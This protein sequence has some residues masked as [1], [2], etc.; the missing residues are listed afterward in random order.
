MPYPRGVEDMKHRNAIR[1]CRRRCHIE[2]LEERRLLANVPVGYTESVLAAELTS[3]TTLDIEE[4]GRIWVAFQDGR[5]E[6]IEPGES[7]TSFAYQLDADG[8][9]EHGLQGIEL[10]PDFENNHYIYV[11]YTA[12]SPQPHNRL[13]RLTVDPTTENTILPGSEVPL[14]E[15]PNLS[16]Y[17]N[18][19]W[20]IGGAIHFDLDGYLY[21]QIGESQQA[22]QSQELDSPLG[23]VFRINA[24]GSIPT[25]NPYYNDADGITW[26]DYIWA[27]GLRNP[28]AGDLDPVTGQYLIADVGGGSW[29]EIN[30]AT[31]P[32]HNFGWPVTEGYFDTAQFPVFTEP[33]YAYSH[34]NG[35][36]IT[37]LAFNNGGTNPFPSEYHGKVF[38]AE[39]C[40]GE[41]RVVDPDDPSSVEVFATSADYPMNIEF[42][43]DGAL[44]YISRGAGAGGAPGIG[45]GTVRR[46]AYAADVAPMVVV[47]PQDQL[48]SVGYT[49]EFS[50]SAAG[51]TPLTYQW[52]VSTGGSFDDIPG[53]N[54]A[55]LVLSDVQLAASGNQYRVVVTNSLGSDV[56]SA[57]TLSVT[58]DQPPTGQITLPSGGTTYRAGDIITYAGAGNDAED[59]SLAPS[60]LTWRVDFHH[61]VHS[62]PFIPP[63]PGSGGSFEI[64]TATETDDDVWYRINLTVTDSA[65]LS[66]STFVDVF[67]EKSDFVV[68]TNLPDG[69]GTLLIDGQAVE[70]PYFDTGV[71][72]V[73]RQLSAPQVQTVDGQTAYFYQ[74]LDGTTSRERT[75]FTPEDDTAY[76]ALYRT[77]D[78]NAVYVSDLTPSETPI[79]GWGPI[80]LDSSNGEQ[81]AGDGQTI[82]LNGV[83]YDKGLGVHSYSEVT[84]DLGS[85]YTRFLSDVGVD[86]EANGTVVF[87]VLG[88]GVE[89]YNSGVVAG[90]SP[91]QTVDVDVSGVNQ[92]KL[93]VEDAGDGD[94]MDHA[95]WAGA[96]LAQPA[97]DPLVNINFQLDTAT[98][99]GGY[100]ADWGQ[101]YGDQGG[102]WNYG[103]SFDHTDVS[104]DR[105]INADQSLDTLVHFHAGGVW[106]IEIPNGQYLV[107]ASVGDAE[108]VSDHTLNVEGQNYWTAEQL[109]PNDF[110]TATHL[111]VVTDGRLTLD[112][113]AAGDKA[114][115]INYLEI[116]TL[117]DSGT[118]LPFTAG[119]VDL[120]GKLDLQDI[121]AFGNGWGV[122][123]STSSL[124]ERVRQGDLDFDGDTD[125]DDWNILNAQWLADNNAPVSPD[126]VL[127]PKPGDY[128]RNGL[129]TAAD[130]SV[131]KSS[132]GSAGA[133]AADGNGDGVVN[134]ADYT[135]W[136]NNLGGNDG[137][138]V[139]LD[140]LVLFVD[141]E[142]GIGTLKNDTHSTLEL[143]GYTIHSAGDA[144]LPDNGDWNSLTDQ[145]VTGW[146]EA[147]PNS[148]ALSEL[149]ATSALSLAPGALLDLGHV[150]DVT[151]E[152]AGLSLEFALSTSV[153]MQPG[154]AVF[155]ELLTELAA[156]LSA[157]L[158][159]SD[160]QSSTFSLAAVESA[161]ESSVDLA[162]LATASRRS[163][164]SPRDEA[165]GTIDTPSDRQHQTAALLLLR[166]AGA[167]DH[168]NRQRSTAKIGGDAQRLQHSCEPPEY[169]KLHE[170]LFAGWGLDS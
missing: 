53:A 164:P 4:S 107:T 140:S 81:A 69:S 84:Y 170:D 72:N 17:G 115:R 83:T 3:P 95:D 85:Q 159:T 130:Y 46:I 45:T 149:N 73:E 55:T 124:E 120:N 87:R 125:L 38:F 27:S 60:Q 18:P 127:N 47:P 58:S 158:Q 96:R 100:L 20:H 56:S 114:T 34:A 25:D 119:D 7:G 5:I 21:V 144:L 148:S 65:G 32:G 6:V 106:E 110:A 90:N 64:P 94:G 150:F 162:A 33:L 132:F 35:C 108:F 156:P 51:T 74:W 62:H 102:G 2:A 128:N 134:L 82:T 57:A 78:D 75:I 109:Q 91:T 117:I 92:L 86:D 23:K 155:S 26:T 121:V 89:L 126:V 129:V 152:H 77:F 48:V 139:F 22:A 16:E 166:Q 145:M 118:L 153:I 169:T 36:A 80:E 147:A 50:A 112:A 24:D 19:P 31:E 105:D 29:E 143:I 54:D 28:F 66:S 67:P 98:T 49:A 103:W 79:N 101:L 9:A 52:Q 133:Y 40:G 8:S 116:A 167:S 42:G 137:A 111:V 76:V 12:N 135:I 88:D 93:I 43:P 99:P 11:Y 131:W 163:T 142:T 113:G 30:D 168:L 136:R 97:S 161:Q 165:F 154:I 160:S 14:L 68:E 61:N 123:G 10:D 15:L 122:D 39:F 141:P 44:Y 138:P 13:S 104:R 71:E 1:E 63:T 146:E 70:G 157:S 59:G 151:A 41:I 37:G